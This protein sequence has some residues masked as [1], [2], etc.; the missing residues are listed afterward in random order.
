MRRAG[1]CPDIGRVVLF[2]SRARGDAQ[3]RSDYDFAVYAASM[4]HSA[5]SRWCLETAEAAPTLCSLDLVLASGAIAD[6]LRRA[7]Q[8]EGVT[9]YERRENPPSD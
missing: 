8:T 3:P 6:G 5:W 4:A 1:D 2:G 7:I 9:V